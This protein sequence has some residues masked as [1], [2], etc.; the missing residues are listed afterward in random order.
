MTISDI[1]GKLCEERM[2]WYLTVRRCFY[3]LYR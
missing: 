1:V 2:L 3:D